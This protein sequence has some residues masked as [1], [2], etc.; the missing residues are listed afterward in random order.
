MRTLYAGA[1]A[2]GLRETISMPKTVDKRAEARRLARI[3]QAHLTPVAD[4][5]VVR[6]A[7]TTS[8]RGAYRKKQRGF[9]ARYPWAISFVAVM[10]VGLVTAY[11][12]VNKLGPFAPPPP[13]QATCNLKTHHCDKAPIMTIN[14]HKT[15]IAT[16]ETAKGNIV[17]QLDAKDA[18]VTVNNFVFLAQQ[19]FF[20]GL[21]FWRV[22]IPG[23]T[24]SPVDGSTS[25]LALIQGATVNKNGQD[26]NS[27]PGYTFKDENLG[28][29]YTTGTVA[30]ANAGAN[31]NGAQFFICTGDNSALLGK[32]YSIFGKVT[33]GL[34]VSQKIAADDVIK[35]VTIQV[36]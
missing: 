29:A 1:L 34:D 13:K 35:T 6:S 17:I 16:I 31:T 30:M 25:T 14:I 22:E 19:H 23:K 8:A 21:Y 9:L 18:P 4:R 20:D 12:Y 3:Q 33:S 32:S 24:V 2:Q 15:Y 5:P 26:P 11:G 28:G 10:L 36:K 27:I 7:S